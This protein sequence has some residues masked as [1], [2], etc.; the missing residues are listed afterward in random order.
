MYTFPGK[1]YTRS[2]KGVR[3]REQQ[4]WQKTVQFRTNL[5]SWNNVFLIVTEV[6]NAGLLCLWLL[7]ALHRIILQNEIKYTTIHQALLL[8]YGYDLQMGT[9][10][11]KKDHMKEA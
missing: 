10:A 1:R 6:V 8:L 2:T 5:F 11:I 7:V 3:L 4:R 9:T